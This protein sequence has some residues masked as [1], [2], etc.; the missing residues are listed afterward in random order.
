MIQDRIN[1]FM[2]IVSAHSSEIL[3]T[4]ATV[5][6]IML[7]FFVNREVTVRH[8]R[9]LW[10]SVPGELTVLTLGFL[11][12]A[13]KE[14]GQSVEF[15]AI[16]IF[17]VLGLYI[18]ECVLERSLSKKLSGSWGRGGL[19]LFFMYMFSILFYIMIVFG[20]EYHE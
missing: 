5:F 12:S 6:V 14:S 19:F 4:I 10:I 9:E 15:V 3:A 1:A 18:L 2:R 8:T 20:G 13:L 17:I 7:K 16:L 11:L